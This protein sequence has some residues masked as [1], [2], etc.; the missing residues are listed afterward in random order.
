MAVL[1][2][3]LVKEPGVVRAEHLPGK[4]APVKASFAGWVAPNMAA[5]S[6]ASA[7][8]VAKPFVL[9][10]GMLGPPAKQLIAALNSKGEFYY[11]DCAYCHQERLLRKNERCF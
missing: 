3:A 1:Q 7:A 6:A 11:A 2:V 5:A 9:K 8:P 4:Q 10:Q